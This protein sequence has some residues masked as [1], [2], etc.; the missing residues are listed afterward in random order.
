MGG[1]TTSS[2]ERVSS[3]R[4]LDLWHDDLRA[5][6]DTASS[7]C[8]FTQIQMQHEAV[9]LSRE[10]CCHSSRSLRAPNLYI[11]SQLL[12]RVVHQGI[13]LSN[14]PIREFAKSRG[15][16]ERLQAAVKERRPLHF[17]VL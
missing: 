4:L 16:C 15:G 13:E 12:W 7:T 5:K 1:A 3:L 11:E 6:F 8:H 14:I 10:Q 9:S 17:L 2:T